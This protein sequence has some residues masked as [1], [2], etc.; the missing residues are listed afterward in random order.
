M[1][2][3]YATAIYDP[4]TGQFQVGD[5]Y[6]DLE[7]AKFAFGAC[8]IVLEWNEKSDGLMWVSKYDG[9]TLFINRIGET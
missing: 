1:T 2:Q 9:C 8:S 3:R 4:N 5:T 6:S 7:T